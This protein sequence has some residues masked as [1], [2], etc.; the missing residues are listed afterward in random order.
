MLLLQSAVLIGIAAWM[1]LRP[2][3]VGILLAFV[4]VSLL[5]AGMASFSYALALSLSDENALASTLNTFMLPLTLLSGILLPL[6]LAPS[7]IQTMARANPFAYIVD[8]ARAL[9]GGLILTPPV[10]IGF[11]VA[12]ALTGLSLWWSLHE[13]Q[14]API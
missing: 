5:G 7:F 6:S 10:L 14:K 8:A 11:V 1:G 12:A 2:N 3:G 13:I 4:L 9:F